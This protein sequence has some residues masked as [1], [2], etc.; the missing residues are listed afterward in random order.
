MR[1]PT[2]TSVLSNIKEV[3]GNRKVII[4]CLCAGLMVG[5]LEGFADV[6][7]TAFLKQAYGL[8][9]TVAA[10]LPSM[11]F[12]GMCFGAPILSLIAEK[13]GYLATITS[14]GALMAITFISLFAWQMPIGLLSLSF[15]IIGTCCAYQILAIYKASTYVREQVVGLTTAVANM[16]IMTFGYVF[17]VLMG[18]IISAMGGPGLSH[19]L[20]AGVTVIPVALGIGT[21]GFIFLSI[22]EKKGAHSLESTLPKS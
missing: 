20:Y 22:N 2:K 8:E 18:T 1:S 15:V 3:L 4:S 16:I 9:G 12:M 21:L 17:H 10:S 6:W 19:A 13:I 11:I 5:P 14:A 7:A